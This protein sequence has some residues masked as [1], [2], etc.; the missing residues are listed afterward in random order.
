MSIGYNRRDFLCT[1]GAGVA[2]LMMN[3]ASATASAGPGIKP[4]TGSW[5][6][7]QHHATVEG[8]DWNPACARFTAAQWQAKVK[9]IADA[10]M[11]YLVL[12]ATA[13]YY[14]AFYE[15]SIFP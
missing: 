15:T 6:E 4:I 12:M 1:L 8:V 2:G 5:F 7:F 11:D 14:R 13:V 3:P 10:G 9:E